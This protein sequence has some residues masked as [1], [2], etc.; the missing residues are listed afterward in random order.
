MNSI[1]E[2]V[3]LAS[4]L[5]GR[6]RKKKPIVPDTPYLGHLL[7]VAGIVQANGG[8]EV[9]VAAALL[10]DAIE[11]QGVEARQKIRE[12]LGQQVLD[13]VEACTENEM[14]PRPPWRERKMAY[15]KLME[16]ASRQAFLV[17]VADKLQNG[18]ALLRR[19]RLEGVEGW[20]KPDREEKLWYLERLLEGMRHRLAQLEQEGSHP[21]LVA[22]RLLVE[23]Y[24]DVVAALSNCS[25][26]TIPASE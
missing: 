21:S 12:K 26:D 4:K 25:G 18:R 11:D 8:D 10:H 3:K 7:E 22:L 5:H 19:V 14:F 9:T 24:A 16:T 20:G 17:M 23:E 13:V 15:L 1:V 6:Q 2:A